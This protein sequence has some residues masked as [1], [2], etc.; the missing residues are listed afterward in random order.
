[1]AQEQHFEGFDSAPEE[2][3]R[4]ARK[5][6]AQK[7]RALAEKLGNIGD[8]SFRALHF[9]DENI[10]EALIVARGLKPH[11]DERRRQLQYVAKLLRQYDLEDFIAE[12]EGLG[13]TPQ[14]D[15]QAMR[16]ENL[17]ENLIA[18]GTPCINAFCSVVRDTDRNKLRTLVKKAQEELKSERPDR[19][20]A[21]ALYRFLKEELNRTAVTLPE[22]LTTKA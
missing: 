19:P 13:A 4:S 15:P 2:I 5:R 12:V 7:I 20:A 14:V 10:E 16:L 17:R 22:E 21:R 8:L 11:S 9:P 6:D 3:S 18:Q 1:M